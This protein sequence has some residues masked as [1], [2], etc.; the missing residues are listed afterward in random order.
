M[1]TVKMFQVN[2]AWYAKTKYGRGLLR[3]CGL[4][5][6]GFLSLT[7]VANHCAKFKICIKGVAP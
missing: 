4:T 3:R 6:G 5:S 1:K 7:L 2:G